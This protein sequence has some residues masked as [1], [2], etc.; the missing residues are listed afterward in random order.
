VKIKARRDASKIIADVA[1]SPGNRVK[2]AVSDIDGVL[3]GK[4][5]HKDKFLAS[6]E[7]G[8]GFCNVVF[9]WDAGDQT[10][11][12][13]SYTGWHTGFPDALAEIDLNTFRRIPW[14]DATPMFLGNFVDAKGAPLAVCPRQ[15]LKRVPRPGRGF[16]CSPEWNS[17][18]SIFARRRKVLPPSNTPRR[19]RSRHRCSAI[20]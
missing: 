1:A 16:R 10:Y 6:A 12:N 4:Y 9:G 13:A 2:V 11:D 17:S 14:D 8:F 7:S 5:M 19:S 15:L 3:R 18:G 20:R